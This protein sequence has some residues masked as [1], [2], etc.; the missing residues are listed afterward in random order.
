M[1]SLPEDFSENIS[2]DTLLT[3]LD[4][5]GLTWLVQHERHS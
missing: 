2:L 5:H 4:G 3:E 1:A